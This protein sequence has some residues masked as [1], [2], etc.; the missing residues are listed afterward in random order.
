M[1][2]REFNS[3]GIYGLSKWAALA[4]SRLVGVLAAAS[5]AACSS[6]LTSSYS[7]NAQQSVPYRLPQAYYDVKLNASQYTLELVIDGPK[8]TGSDQEFEFSYFKS[9]FSAGQL[10]IDVDPFTGLPTAVTFSSD[11]RAE[12]V[13]SA[14]GSAV[15]S[16]TGLSRDPSTGSSV[17]DPQSGGLSQ[18]TAASQTIFS[19]RFYI[20]GRGNVQADSCAYEHNI[21]SEVLVW[22]GDTYNQCFWGKIDFIASEWAKK[23]IPNFRHA[24]RG[25]EALS[26]IAFESGRR[27]MKAGSTSKQLCATGVCYARYEPNEFRISIRGSQGN[28]AYSVPAGIPIELLISDMVPNPTK[29]EMLRFSAG[30]FSDTTQQVIFAE[31]TPTHIALVKDSEVETILRTPANLIGGF[32]DGILRVIPLRLYVDIQRRQLGQLEA[33]EEVTP[34]ALPANLITAAG[35]R[36]LSFETLVEIAKAQSGVES[37]SPTERKIT[38][39]Q[40][41]VPPAKNN[42]GAGGTTAAGGKPSSDASVQTR[43]NGQKVK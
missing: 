17:T 2:F 43:P 30:G 25:S 18:P 10:D 14:L 8:I 32:F 16:L 11:S 31:G 42:N 5:L 24:Q 41:P 27:E 23:Y 39:F 35:D 20:D 19:D 37:L 4:L 15:G 21:A 7:P 33:G 28:G 34:T 29:L 22:R 13:S 12:E 26:I 6:S 40:R 9:P 36:D 1:D 38:L 3:R